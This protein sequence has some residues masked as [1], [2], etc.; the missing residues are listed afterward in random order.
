MERVSQAAVVLVGSV[1]ECGKFERERVASRD[2]VIENNVRRRGRLRASWL[3]S[4]AL[5]VRT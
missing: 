3:A 1:F 4:N 2:H 5:P